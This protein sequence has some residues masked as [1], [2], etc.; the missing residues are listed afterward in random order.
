MEQKEDAIRCLRCNGE[1]IFLMQ[2]NLQLGKTGWILGDLPNLLAGGLS[3][4]IYCCKN[5]GKLEFFRGGINEEDETYDGDRIGKRACPKCA[6]IHD[7][8]YPKCPFCGF[9]YYK[10]R[11]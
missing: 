1:M 3:V 10:K 9:D 2:E 8:D 5:C 7:A 6:S 4:E 11:R